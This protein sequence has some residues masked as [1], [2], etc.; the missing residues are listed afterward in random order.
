MPKFSF[1]T[2]CKGRLHH[3]QQTLPLM[4][5]QAD[6]ECIVV[7]YN[8]PQKTGDWVEKNYPQVKV[9]RET[10]D[11]WNIS[12]ARNLGAQAANTEWLVFIDADIRLTGDLFAWLDPRLAPG[13]FF[14][15]GLTREKMDNFGTF[16]CHRNDFAKTGGYDE[17]LRGWGKED[18]D[19]YYRLRKS[20]CAQHFF[21]AH[22]L[23][24]IPHDDTQRTQYSPYK[25]RWVSHII[26]SLYL[27]MKYDMESLQPE[28]STADTHQKLYEHARLNVLRIVSQGPNADMT[29]S[30]TL[31]NH[32]GIPSQSPVW[33]V[34]RKLVY[35]LSPRQF[36]LGQPGEANPDRPGLQ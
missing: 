36:S 17:L 8:C 35:T 23:D 9:V 14:R 1:I 26:S 31:G 22:I 25:S 32:P 15:A 20:G 2:T 27:Q 4:V 18:N 33:E 34:Q 5:S 12:R 21:P 19:M 7:D 11:A 28:L 16:T 3:L 13:N 24:P 10:N 29:V 30:V 6:S